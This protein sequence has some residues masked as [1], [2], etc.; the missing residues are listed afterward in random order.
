MLKG[1]ATDK[2][3]NRFWFASEHSTK[4]I[5]TGTGIRIGDALASFCA[6]DTPLSRRHEC[7]S[8]LSGACKA[9]GDYLSLQRGLK[10]QVVEII[11]RRENDMVAN[12]VGWCNGD[13]YSEDFYISE[14]E[15]KLR[16]DLSQVAVFDQCTQPTNAREFEKTETLNKLVEDVCDACD[17]LINGRDPD[18]P[19]VRIRF[20]TFGNYKIN[21]CDI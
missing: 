17:G 9:L 18:Q 6:S 15:G 20:I 4:D 13:V 10:C 1:W 7:H 21:V 12:V 8:L 5:E 16:M 19:N 3:G 11:P 2:T 14:L